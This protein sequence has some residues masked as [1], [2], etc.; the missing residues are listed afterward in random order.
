MNDLRPY[1]LLQIATMIV[2]PVA[3]QS[4]A[5]SS[6]ERLAFGIAVGCYVLAKICEF[7]DQRLFAMLPLSGH[8]LKHLLAGLGAFAI[9]RYFVCRASVRKASTSG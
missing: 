5:A 9:A 8:T 4:A 7:A 3:Q 1:L 6:R 2:I